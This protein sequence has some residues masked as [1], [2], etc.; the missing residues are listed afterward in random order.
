MH[1][2][3]IIQIQIK[4]TSEKSIQYK[5]VS[6]ISDTI[7]VCYLV[8]KVIVQSDLFSFLTQPFQICYFFADKN[9]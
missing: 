4:Y 6:C 5:Y 8:I 1:G 3:K 2:Q 9:F 7:Q